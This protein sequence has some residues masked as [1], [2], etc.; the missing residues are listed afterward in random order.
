MLRPKP[1][2]YADYPKTKV[3]EGSCFVLGDA[4]DN[5]TDSRSFG[6]VSL[7]DVIGQVQYVWCPAE[8]WT[9]FGAVQE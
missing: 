3:P 7:G 5:S 9:R 8:T 6:C 4:R 1:S 2:E